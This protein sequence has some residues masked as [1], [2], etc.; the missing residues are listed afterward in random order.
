MADTRGVS[1]HGWGDEPDCF[2][3][4]LNLEICVFHYLTVNGYRKLAVGRHLHDLASFVCGYF[5]EFGVLKIG[6][7]GIS[8]YHGGKLN[9]GYG[10]DKTYV[11]Q[12]VV[13]Q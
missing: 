1:L 8:L 3:H 11:Y 9:D 13:I 7:V 12:S 4:Y 6:A 2:V 5:F 10:G